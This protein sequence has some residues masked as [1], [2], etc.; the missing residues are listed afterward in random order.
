M[1]DQG[2]VAPLGLWLHFGS[3]LDIGGFLIGLWQLD[4]R[5]A[6][7]LGLPMD[8]EDYQWTLHKGTRC[9]NTNKFGFAW[10]QVNRSG[11]AHRTVVAASAGEAK[12]LRRRL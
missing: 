9:S 2:K 12:V 3:T 10:Q 8:F 1:G 4:C 5:T 6:D 11:A 7:G